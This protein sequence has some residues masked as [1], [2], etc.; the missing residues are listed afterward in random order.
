MKVICITG[1]AQHGK[2]TVASMIRDYLQRRGDRVL[3]A[4]CADLLKY[5]CKTFFNWDGQKDECGRY[6]V[7]YIGTDVVRTQKPDYW[8]SFIKGIIELFSSE[9]DYVLIPDVRFPNEYETLKGH[10]FNATLL[11]IVRPGFDNGL[12]EDQKNHESETA[13]D[14]YLSD[15]TIINDGDLSC[16][17]L[18][19][20]DYFEVLQ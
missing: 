16:L 8:V 6:L 2:D 10:P 11:R 17:E 5:I 20:K 18:R 13:L 1:K 3:I 19:I 4:H 9:W 12:T 14:N 15:Y 7:Q